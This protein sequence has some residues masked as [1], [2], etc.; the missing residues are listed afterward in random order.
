MGGGQSWGLT[1]TLFFFT[2]LDSLHSTYT[3]NTKEEGDTTE[4]KWMKEKREVGQWQ[5]RSQKQGKDYGKTF[6]ERVIRWSLP[7]NLDRSYI[8]VFQEFRR[9]GLSYFT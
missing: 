2:R 5:S 7:K 4:K 6:R 1:S 8:W 3:P 9:K